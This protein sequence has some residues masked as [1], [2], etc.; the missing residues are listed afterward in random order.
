MSD[1]KLK[2]YV[3][4]DQYMTSMKLK[5]YINLEPRPTT[6]VKD[7]LGGRAD[8]VTSGG[9]VNFPLQSTSGGSS[10]VYWFVIMMA[11]TR[12]LGNVSTPLL[13]PI[14]LSAIDRQ[15]IGVFPC[16]REG[17]Q[18]KDYESGDALA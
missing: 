2:I 10:G 18:L 8:Y 15:G 13:K 6:R 17:S 16:T 3:L 1:V 14:L 9:Q 4:I 7:S 5:M 11:A 12:A